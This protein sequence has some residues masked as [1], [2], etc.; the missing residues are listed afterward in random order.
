MRESG[1]EVDGIESKVD[2]YLYTK[3]GGTPYL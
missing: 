2:L 3:V 1:E